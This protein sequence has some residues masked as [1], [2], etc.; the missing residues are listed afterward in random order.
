MVT[1]MEAHEAKV[2]LEEER[3]R[4]HNL[5]RGAITMYKETEWFL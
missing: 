3:H 1:R 5:E 4:G 2:L